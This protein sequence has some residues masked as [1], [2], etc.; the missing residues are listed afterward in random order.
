MRK[1]TMVFYCLTTL[2]L[3]VFLTQKIAASAADFSSID[4]SNQKAILYYVNEYRAKHHLKPLKMN[5]LMSEEAAKHSREMARHAIPF[6]HKYFD[7]RIHRLFAEIGDCKGGSENVAYN[8]KDAKDVV[9]NWLTS[10]GHRRNIEGNFN[11]TGI[12][13]ARDSR[14][15]LYFTQI[16]IRTTNP[17][18]TQKA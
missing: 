8:Y 14:G 7:K 1:K 4:S 11:L 13:L 3:T 6:G 15:K 16:F 2:F 10:S 9:K 5:N 17:V 18:Y 12:G